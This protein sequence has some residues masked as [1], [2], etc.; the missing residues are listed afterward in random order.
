G[1]VDGQF[2]SSL[3][4]GLPVTSDALQSTTDGNDFY[5]FVLKKNATAQLF[6]SF[7]GQNGGLS[8][9]V[10]GGTSRFD[11]QGVIYQAICAN[12]FGN[13]VGAISVPYPITP[14]VW[15]PVNGTGTSNC[16]LAAAKIA[17]NFAGVAAGPQSY[18]N[19]AVDTLGCV[20]FTV[21]LKDTILNAKSYVW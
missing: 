7:W 21:T 9:H 8:D 19:N 4:T 15:G 18:F 17:F 12:C 1:V 5:F 6:G 20:T 13:A 2:K 14:G 16:N 3:T 10:D 11:K